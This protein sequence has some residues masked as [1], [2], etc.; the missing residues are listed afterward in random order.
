MR[1]IVILIIQVKSI[2]VEIDMA[3]AIAILVAQMPAKQRCGDRE[4]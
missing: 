4:E 2:V 1:M 3:P